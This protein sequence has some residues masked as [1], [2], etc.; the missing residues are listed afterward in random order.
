MTRRTSAQEVGLMVVA[1]SGGFL[2]GW[3]L[4]TRAREGGADPYDSGVY[5]EGALVA[6]ALFGLFLPRIP[7]VVTGVVAMSVHPIVWTFDAAD[8]P[9]YSPFGALGVI[10]VIGYIPILLLVAWGAR[11]ARAKLRPRLS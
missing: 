3:L 10:F 11:F 9:P 5:W 6:A 4:W 7:A 1:G 2:I 8:E